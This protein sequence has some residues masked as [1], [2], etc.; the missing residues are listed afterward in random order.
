MHVGCLEIVMFVLEKLTNCKIKYCSCAIAQNSMLLH[1]L[2]EI[3]GFLLCTIC[4][5][6]ILWNVIAEL[7]HLI[8]CLA[9]NNF[10]EIYYSI[11]C[12]Q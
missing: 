6:M 9:L 1:V 7:F 2:F 8:M 5:S 10:S 3:R 12:H 11:K 4:M